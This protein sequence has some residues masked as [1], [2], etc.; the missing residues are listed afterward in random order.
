MQ[1]QNFSTWLLNIGNGT[2]GDPDETDNQNTFVVHMPPELCIPDSNTAL[3]ALIHVI[4]DEKTLQAPTAKDMQRKAIV[5]PKN[6][7]ADM[8]NAQV[9]SLVNHQQH[10]YQSL[11]EAVPHGNDGGETELLYPAEYLNSLNFVGFPP[12]RLEL[13]V[14]T[15]TITSLAVQVLEET[16]VGHNPAIID[17]GASESAKP[18]VEG[19]S[20]TPKKYPKKQDA[21]YSKI[22]K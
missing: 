16:F 7:N 2:I 3:A 6:E 5:C 21:A 17:E 18:D 19:P 12:H 22:T 8:I 14:A 20:Q 15:E 4:Y 1:I 13:K 9:L 11:D 10:V